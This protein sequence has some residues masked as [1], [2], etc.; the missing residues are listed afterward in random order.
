MGSCL[1]GIALDVD[2][3]RQYQMNVRKGSVL[4]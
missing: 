2:E 4:T 3:D 1:E